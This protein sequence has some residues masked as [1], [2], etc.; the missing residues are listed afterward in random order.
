MNSMTETTQTGDQINDTV[1][2]AAMIALR[3]FHLTAPGQVAPM[4]AFW[5]R[6][7]E[8]TDADVAEVAERMF[9][10]PLPLMDCPEWCTADHSR[11]TYDEIENL[12]DHDREILIERDEEGR[13]KLQVLVSATDNLS[14]RH[15]NPGGILIITDEPLTPEQA[16]RMV[17]AVSEGLRILAA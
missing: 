12:C 13:I 4:L 10:K 5:I 14:E 7:D 16:I 17:G 9:P 1:V 8:M 15:R 11:F 6:R 2:E 3:A